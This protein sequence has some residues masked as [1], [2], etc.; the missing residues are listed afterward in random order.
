MEL[1]AKCEK[2]S[3]GCGITKSIAEFYQREESNKNFKICIECYKAAR[4]EKY[5]I[6]S[7][8]KP[9]YREK[10]QKIKDAQRIKKINMRLREFRKTAANEIFNL[11]R[12]GFSYKRE[13]RTCGDMR[14]DSL[15][16][17]MRGTL[18][19]PFCARMANLKK[20]GKIDISQMSP[21][22]KTQISGFIHGPQ[23]PQ[24]PLREVIDNAWQEY[25][26]N[27]EERLK[28]YAERR[29]AKKRGQ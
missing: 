27:K 5:K 25:I 19:C 1:T 10:L 16:K 23:E 3:G 2:K 15:S 29:A 17:V 28:R 4:R 13:C 9:T 14:I 12:H 24:S 26:D 22:S 20:A 7:K 21:N 18:R 11:T 8:K 6:Q